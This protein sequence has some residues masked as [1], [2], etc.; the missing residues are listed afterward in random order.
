MA[1]RFYK[2]NIAQY[3][4]LSFEEMLFAPSLMR[5]QHDAL[6]ASLAETQTALGNYNV[7]SQDQDFVNQAVDPVSQ[8]LTGMAEQLAKQGFSQQNMSQFRKLASQKNKLFS[9]TG[10]VG[11]AQSRLAAFQTKVKELKETYKDNPEIANYYINQLTKSPGLMRDEQGNLVNQSLAS[12]NN[13]RHYDAK[14]ISDMLNSQIDNIKDTLIKDY[15]FGKTGSISSIQDVYREAQL[16]GRSA[17]E[18]NKI[19]LAQVSPEVVRSAQQ[20]GLVTMGSAEAGVQ[21]LMNQVAG[22]AQGRAS[23][24]LDSNYQ[25]V[26]NEDRKFDRDQ[27]VA[28]AYKG[29]YTDSSRLELPTLNPFADLTF[30]DGQLTSKS[31]NSAAL[32]SGKYSYISGTGATTKEKSASEQK[33]QE[34]N[35]LFKK[36]KQN[37]PTLSGMSDEEAYKTI[38]NYY[39]NISQNYMGRA[40]FDKNIDVINQTLKGNLL[41]STFM[42]SNGQVINF[43]ELAETLG[44]TEDEVITNFKGTSGVELNPV[45]GASAPITLTDKSGKAIQLYQQLDKESQSIVGE[46]QKVLQHLY[47]NANSAEINSQPLGNGN[48]LNTYVINDFVNEPVVIKTT[49][50]LSPKDLKEFTGQSAQAIQNALPKSIVSGVKEVVGQTTRALAS[51]YQNSKY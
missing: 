3:N 28:N 24:N 38:N 12:I 40:N 19:L 21:S 43:S 20:Y 45:I 49:A 41:N 48:Y 4:P 32:S 47:S 15:G 9:P 17:E 25:I 7:L 39:T 50:N 42:T 22:A 16:T 44:M 35:L 51:N 10:E 27:K 18:V 26:T 11:I 30:K 2:Q 37:N 31:G 34:S 29:L 1:A 13:V 14:Q 8:E 33:V 5:K 23:M 6:D 36:I 46:T